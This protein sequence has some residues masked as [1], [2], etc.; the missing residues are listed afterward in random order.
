MTQVS[1]LSAEGVVKRCTKCGEDKSP[2]TDFHR[3]R[4][5]PDGLCRWCKTCN[6][7]YAR[8]L[9]KQVLRQRREKQRKTERGYL[10]EIRMNAR[11]R[12]RDRGVPFALTLDDLTVPPDRC[13]CCDRALLR[14][15]PWSNQP[16]LDCIYPD[17]G[18]IV[19]NVQWLCRR[20]NVLKNNAAPE[21]LMMVA[22]FVQK[23]VKGLDSQGETSL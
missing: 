19:G 4:Y 11:K 13:P 14:R 16:S 6:C 10:H 7:E 12:A 23:V 9:D 3:N 2:K 5:N 20:C 8:N 18:Y 22:L 17:R 15:G 21:E 1:P